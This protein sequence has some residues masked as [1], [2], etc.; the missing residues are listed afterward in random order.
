MNSGPP[1]R[2]TAVQVGA[3]RQEG[4][5]RVVDFDHGQARPGILPA[6]IE[7]WSDDRRRGRRGLQ[8]LD[9]PLALDERDVAR[10]CFGNRSRRADRETSVS[11]KTASHQC[12]QLFDRCNH[13]FFLSSLKGEDENRTWRQW[14][15]ENQNAPAP[16]DMLRIRSLSGGLSQRDAC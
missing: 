1:G 7:V 15:L 6:E 8:Q 4:R 13:R 12:R 3:D 16:I 2:G 9:E 14:M 10:P 11:D 5:H